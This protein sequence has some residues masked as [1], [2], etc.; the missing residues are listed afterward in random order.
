[1]EPIQPFRFDLADGEHVYHLRA[2]LPDRVVETDVAAVHEPGAELRVRDALAAASSMTRAVSAAS[3]SS[4]ST[5]H[6]SHGSQ[7]I[8][9][10]LC[11]AAAMWWVVP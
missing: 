7:G 3:N 2:H 11:P 6:S 5:P 4:T 9:P 8:A 1:V 10:T